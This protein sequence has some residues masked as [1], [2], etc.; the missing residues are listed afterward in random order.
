MGSELSKTSQKLLHIAVG[1]GVVSLVIAMFGL[2][3]TSLVLVAVASVF[4]FLAILSNL[5]TKPKSKYFGESPVFI[6]TKP[7]SAQKGKKKVA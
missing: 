4:V 5:F 6:E 2:Y 1:I 3:L 7:I